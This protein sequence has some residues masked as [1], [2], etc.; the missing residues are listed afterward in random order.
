MSTK[1]TVRGGFNP[2]SSDLSRRD[3]LILSA[4][5]VAANTSAFAQ[6]AQVEGLPKLTVT[7]GAPLK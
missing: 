1:R 7:I 5:A 6:M 3:I 2:N 4:G